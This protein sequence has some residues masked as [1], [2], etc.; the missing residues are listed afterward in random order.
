MIFVL[1][2]V[3]GI[4][5]CMWTYHGLAYAIREATRYTSVHGVNCTTAPN[6]C[7]A[8][9]GNIASVLKN[10]SPALLPNQ[11]TVTF[12]PAAGSA[13]TDTLANLLLN[14]TAWPP[15]SPTGT[16]GVGKNV[17]IS[18]VYSFYSPIAMFWPG[19]RPQS[20]LGLVY[21]SASSTDQIQF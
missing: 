4:A 12:S 20:M 1:I 17:T 7:G 14:N 10:A 3:V 2:S 19:T 18:A 9:I 15:S 5:Q 11:L 8:T 21:L 6:T 16:N 13:T